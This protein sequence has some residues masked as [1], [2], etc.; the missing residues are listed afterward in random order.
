[1][2]NAAFESGQ[3]NLVYVAHEIDSIEKGIRALRDLSFRGASVTIPFKTEV[4]KHLDVIDE[5]AR[6]IGAVNTIVNKNG[7]L[8]G[9][10][11]DGMGACNAISCESPDFAGSKVLVLGSGGASRAV[12]FT[13]IEHGGIVTVASRSGPSQDSLV[14]ALREYAPETASVDISTL[15]ANDCAAF[16]VIINTTP[17]GMKD[18]DPLPLPLE[19]IHPSHTLFDIV[20]HHADTPWLLEGRKR[21]AKTVNGIEMLVRQGTIQYELWTGKEAPL[22]TMKSALVAALG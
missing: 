5:T 11:T 16:D 20:Y 22:E 1:M 18:G 14:A 21:G 8:H 13:M 10:N 9:Y 4:M 12:A 19:C 17:L 15:T 7:I 6:R 2:H 3:D